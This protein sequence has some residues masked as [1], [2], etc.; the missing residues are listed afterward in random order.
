MIEPLGCRVD[1]AI[2]QAWERHFAPDRQLFFVSDELA[3]RLPRAVLNAR[4]GFDWSSVPLSLRDTFAVWAVSPEP[5]WLA[6]FDEDAFR[7]LPARDRAAVLEEQERWGR[8]VI[9]RS[10]IM[11]LWLQAEDRASLRQFAGE[12]RFVFWPGLW[13]SLS[14]PAREQILSGFVAEGGLP[15]QRYALSDGHWRRVDAV[16]PGVRSLAGTF[17]PE[18]GGNCLGT[19]MAAHGDSGVA[20]QWVQRD[21]F[22]RWLEQRFCPAGNAEHPGSVLVWHAP[23]GLVQHAAVSLGEGMVFHKEAQTWWTPRQVMALDD[24]V[25]RLEEWGAP[26][27]FSPTGDR[28]TLDLPRGTVS[29]S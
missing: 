5:A 9:Y 4:E 3:G 26:T 16:L 17:L 11:E 2:L 29:G 7:A 28:A 10:E 12:G 1:D 20:G 6:W 27:V 25:A 21:V 22:E 19:T 18:S 23:D 24:A 15:C 13:R 8:G 14:L